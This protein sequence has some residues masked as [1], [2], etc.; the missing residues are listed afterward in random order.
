MV[1]AA[2]AFSDPI[3]FTPR[4]P[5]LSSSLAFFL[6]PGG[7]GA[8]RGTSVRGVVLEAAVG[9]GIVR[10]SHDDAVGKVSSPAA[11]PAQNGVGDHG[12]RRIFVPFGKHDLDLVGRE[13]LKS[14]RAG[15]NRQGV[16]VDA[17][18]ERPIDALT[19]AVLADRL[20]DGQDV[21]FVE[22]AVKRRT[23]VP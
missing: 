19:A 11:V 18:V 4:S 14:G 22:G 21:V 15:R 2:R 20:G 3:R 9:R 17:Q 12:S 16:G 23:A 1:A 8:V 5:A 7:D 10:R 6:D 13:N